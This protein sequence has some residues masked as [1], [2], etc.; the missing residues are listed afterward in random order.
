MNTSA[1]KR[2]NIIDHGLCGRMVKGLKFN[3]VKYTKTILI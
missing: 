3:D 1:K 2:L